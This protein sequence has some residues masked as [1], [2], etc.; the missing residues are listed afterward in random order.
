MR[1]NQKFHCKG[2]PWVLGFMI[3][4]YDTDLNSISYKWTLASFQTQVY[5]ECSFFATV[6]FWEYS[7]EQN[8]QSLFLHRD[9]LVVKPTLHFH[10]TEVLPIIKKSGKIDIL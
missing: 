1:L 3:S 5:M 4:N 2:I 8:G 9:Y 6:S 10:L 7:S